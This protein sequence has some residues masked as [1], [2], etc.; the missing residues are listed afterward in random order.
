MFKNKFWFTIAGVLVVLSMLL[1]A[2]AQPTPTPE[3]IERTVE[4]TVETVVTATPGPTATPEPEAVESFEDVPEDVLMQVCED[5][6][7]AVEYDDEA[8]TVTIHLAEPF[9]P[10]LQ[11][12]ANGWSAPLNQEWIA[13]QGGWDGACETWVEFHDPAAEESVLFDQVNGT[14]PFM[15]EDWRKGEETSL[16]RFEDYYR[17]E[18]IWEG[19]PMGP[20]ALER[21]VIRGV[22][23]WGTRYALFEAGDTDMTYVPRQYAEQM[24]PLVAEECDYQTEECEVVDADGQA[25]LFA[26]L[27]SVSSVDAFFNFQIDDEGGNPY[28]GS[29]SLGDGIPTD[30]FSDIHIRKAFNYAFDWETYIEDAM[31]GEAEQ[32]L[33][34]IINPMLGYNEDDFRYSLDLEM[35]EQEFM[36]ADVDKDGIP[37]GEDEEGDVWTTGFQMILTYNEGN[38]QR[39][40]MAEILKA[41][42]E[43]IND[44]FTVDI[45]AIPWPTYLKGMVAGRLPLFFIGWLEDYHHPHNWVTPYM[46][47]SGTFSAWQHFPQEMY[48]EFD[49]KIAEALTFVDPE[50]ADA[51]YNELQQLAVE[52]AIDIFGVQPFGRHYEQSWVEGWYYNAAYPGTYFYALDKADDAPNPDTMINTTIGEQETLDPAWMYDTASSEIVFNVY[53]SL[54]FMDREDYS[55]FVPAIAES[56]EISEDGMTYTFQIRDGVTFHNGD[57]LMAHHAAYA[58]WRGLLQDRAGGPQWMFWEPIMGAHG[59]EGYAVDKANE[60]AGAE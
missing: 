60:M 12:L 1:S 48:D 44:N 37:A 21:A 4:T 47:S 28:V 43:S 9:A 38:D 24:E 27:P 40:T 14:G 49:E 46:A 16:V 13:E 42:I 32:R 30:F 17:E 52:N 50:E 19:G 41:N 15:L 51:A 36:M 31:L 53:D 29:G 8:G 58:I 54:I 22:D 23:E 25:R 45:L 11:T 18:P 7:A 6:K 10:F 55:N 33:G 39:R 2:C 34:P 59:V 35:A 5:V 57:E 3:V 26:G 20:A 56:W